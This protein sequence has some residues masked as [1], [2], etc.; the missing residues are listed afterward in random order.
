[1]DSVRSFPA[2]LRFEG[3]TVDDQFVK[4]QAQ[5]IDI[6]CARERFVAEL[7]WGHVAQGPSRQPGDR[8]LEGGHAFSAETLRQTEIQHFD[9]PIRP[10]HEVLRLDVAMHYAL[11]VR[12]CQGR[13][14]LLSDHGHLPPGQHGTA[15]SVQ[16]FTFHQFHGDR[17]AGAGIDDFMDRHDIGVIQ[18]RC[19]LGFPN[20]SFHRRGVVNGPGKQEFQGHLPAQVRVPA[21]INLAHAAAAQQICRRDSAPPAFQCGRSAERQAPNP[22]RL[23]RYRAR[24]VPRRL[25]S[26]FQDRH[27]PIRRRAAARRREVSRASLKTR[28][29]FCHCSLFIPGGFRPTLPAASA[30]PNSSTSRR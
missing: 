7:L 17:E 2:V 22:R 29:A 26:Q 8:G 9:N 15:E 21:G 3:M 11:L 12:G 14:D 23:S 18:G 19:R 4:H 1:M 28:Q 24:P 6:A 5:G 20:E 10:E 27:T 13:R 25:A 30:E 16:R